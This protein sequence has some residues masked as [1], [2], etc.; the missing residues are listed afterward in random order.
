MEAE[1]VE[2]NEDLTD[3]TRVELD[4][5]ASPTSGRRFTRA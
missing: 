1:A 5:E 4:E 2:E 3:P